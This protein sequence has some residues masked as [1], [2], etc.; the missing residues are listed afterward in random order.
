MHRKNDALIPQKSCS[1]HR[2]P[3]DRPKTSPSP[4]DPE[5]GVRREPVRDDAWDVFADEEAEA[6][7]PE[8]GDFWPDRDE[9][10]E[11]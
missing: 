8:Y 3:S 11:V 9:N 10:D 4:A 2:Q 5:G 6:M 1:G 7:E